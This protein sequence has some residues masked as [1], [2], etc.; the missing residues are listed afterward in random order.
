L[1]GESY[2]GRRV[3]DV[4]RTIDL[5]VSCGAKKIDL[6]GR[7]QGALLAAFTGL[8]APQIVERV[9]LRNAPQSFLEWATVPKVKWPAANFPRGVLTS[10]DIPDVI[11]ALGRRVRVIEPWDTSMEPVRSIRFRHK[12]RVRKTGFKF[13]KITKGA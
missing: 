2:L 10:F 12:L 4:L 13:S 7:G 11:R 6:V 9:T 5:L 8:L 1:F 3:Y